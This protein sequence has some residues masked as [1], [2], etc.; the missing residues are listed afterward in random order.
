MLRANSSDVGAASG[1][2]WRPF[3]CCVPSIGGTSATWNDR[4]TSHDLGTAVS[5]FTAFAQV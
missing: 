5:G 4:G 2:G 1:G 3:L